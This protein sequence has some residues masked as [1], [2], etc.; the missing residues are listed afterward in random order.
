MV[1]LRYCPTFWWVAK[2]YLRH[3]LP[4]RILLLRRNLAPWYFTTIYTQWRS[5]HCVLLITDFLELAKGSFAPHK[6][7]WQRARMVER[8]SCDY[9]AKC[10]LD[11]TAWSPT[12]ENK[13]RWIKYI[14]LDARSIFLNVLMITGA[15]LCQ[16]PGC[17][18]EGKTIESHI[19]Q[20]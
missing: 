11:F 7:S 20:K 8:E 2:V 3:T 5:C 15:I 19:A 17:R 13:S 4:T 6:D 10:P 14:F 9:L 12:I 1:L 18:I 16:L